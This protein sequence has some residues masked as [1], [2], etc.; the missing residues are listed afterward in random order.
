MVRGKSN[1][2]YWEYIH[3]VRSL[4]RRVIVELNFKILS[5]YLVCTNLT[6]GAGEEGGRSSISCLMMLEKVKNI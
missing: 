4:P 6:V 1:K 3:R 5:E 2:Y